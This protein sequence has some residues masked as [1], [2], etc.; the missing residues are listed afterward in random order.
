MALKLIAI[1][2]FILST[3]LLSATLLPYLYYQYVTGR[4][5]ERLVEP[6]LVR[7][8][9]AVLTFIIDALLIK[10]FIDIIW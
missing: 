9:L 6:H 10:G 7:G 8:C 3:I 1:A 2:I 4:K 5:I